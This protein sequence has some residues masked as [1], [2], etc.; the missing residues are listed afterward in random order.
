[1]SRRPVNLAPR[2][3]T[4]SAVT[5]SFSP[6]SVPQKSRS[7]PLVSIC[8]LL[9]GTIFL[10][11]YSFSNH[12]FHH[13]HST[14]DLS[15]VHHG[16]YSSKLSNAVTHQGKGYASESMDGTEAD[17]ST[18]PQCRNVV[19]QEIPLLKEVYG[20]AMNQILHIGPG[21]C[22]VVLKL[23]TEEKIEAWGI[24]PFDLKPPIHSLCESLIRKGFIRVADSFRTLPYRANSFSLVL[25]TDTLGTLTSRQLNATL[26]DLARISGDGL[27]VFISNKAIPRVL[28]QAGEEG[29]ALKPLKPRNRFWWQRHFQMSGLQENEEITKRFEYLQSKKS[30][31]PD[32]F[33]FH[34]NS[35]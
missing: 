17:Q 33:I 12:G 13:S 23:L 4:E 2:R 21:T 9:L 34:L 18:W 19:C 7:P 24:Q 6:S 32:Y 15:K 29:K 16:V 14:E 27:V 8:L 5:G 26:P 28:D 11:G 31:K 25:V 10:V 22:G 3:F 1:M 30:Y 35:I 20:D